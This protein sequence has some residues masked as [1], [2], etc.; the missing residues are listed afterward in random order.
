M[1]WIGVLAVAAMALCAGLLASGFRLGH[2]WAVAILAALAI[3]AER[4]RIRLTPTLEVS[5][6]SLLCVFAAVVLGPIAAI[7]VGGGAVLAD[8]PRRDVAQPVLRWMTWTGIAVIVAGCA[9]LAAVAVRHAV[10][11]GFWGVV[12]VVAAAF[13]VGTL[14]IRLSSQ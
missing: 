2:V 10:G 9:G 12:A 7:V 1:A 13:V 11:F 6:V 4:E 5:I 8:L 3:G 14:P